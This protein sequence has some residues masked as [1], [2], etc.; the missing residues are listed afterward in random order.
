MAPYAPIVMSLIL[1]LAFVIEMRSGRIPNWLTLFPFVLF[2]LVLVTSPDPSVYGPQ[3]IGAAV[4]MVVGL[5]LFA[6]AGF[7]A[8]AVKLLTGVALFVPHDKALL[9]FGIFVTAMF[10]GSFVIL[11]IRKRFGNPDSRW[12]VLSKGVLPMSLPIGVAGLCAFW[13]I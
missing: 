11:Q 7:G 4:V 13:L 3:L 5:V 6:V 1:V 2:M 12:I 9:T 8:G 10:V